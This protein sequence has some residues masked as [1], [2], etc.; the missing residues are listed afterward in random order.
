MIHPTAIVDPAAR[1]AAD[2]EVG[3]YSVIGPDVEIDAG[4]VIGPHVVIKGPTRLGQRNRI[5]QFASVGEECQDKK[6]AGEPTRLEVGDDNVIRESV[7]IHRGTVQ[8]RGV[9]TIGSRNLFMAYSHVGH[10]C[11][12]GDDCILA[13]QAT[14]AGH[15]T[16]GNFSILGGLSAIHQF[17]HMGEHAMVG[18]CSAITKDIPAF[19]MVSGN[20]A[21][22]HGLNSI[23]L[24]RRGFSAEAI[25]ALGE[26]YRLVYRKGLTLEQ[27]VAEIESRFALEETQRFVDSLKVSQRGIIR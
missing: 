25:K 7:T 19:I 13:N 22:P 23:G 27:A 15:V 11:L 9:T 18:G 26:G 24:K 4:C 10:D 14:L 16:L 12:I 21:A 2:V 3:P 5:F 1:L 6:Y 20:P 8:D 17:C